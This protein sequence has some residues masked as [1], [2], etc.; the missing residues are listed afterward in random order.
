MVVELPMSA[1]SATG[2]AVAATLELQELVLLCS[3]A[4]TATVAPNTPAT[5]KAILLF[6]IDFFYNILLDSPYIC[7]IPYIYF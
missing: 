3:A 4:V 6:K 5:A 7:K 2:A 1:G